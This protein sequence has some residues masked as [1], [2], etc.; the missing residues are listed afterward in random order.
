M[1]AWI[2]VVGVIARVI[3]GSFGNAALERWRHSYI[4]KDARTDR[5][6]ATLRAALKWAS[7]WS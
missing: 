7:R 2:G 4:R 6:A 1:D 3:I 5:Q